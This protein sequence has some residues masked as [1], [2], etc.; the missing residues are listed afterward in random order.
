M[1]DHLTKIPMMPSSSPTESSG[2]G[3]TD[4]SRGGKSSTPT[5]TSC[6]WSLKSVTLTWL[7]NREEKLAL[8]QYESL[9]HLKFFTQHASGYE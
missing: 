7:G 6:Q 3:G 4:D 1:E 8:K 2:S 9:K 5:T